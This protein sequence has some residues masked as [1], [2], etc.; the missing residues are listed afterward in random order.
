MIDD[1]TMTDYSYIVSNRFEAINSR[2][3]KLMAEQIKDIGKLSPSNL[4][5]LEQ[6]TKMDANIDEINRLLAAECNKA[7]EE[8][9]QIYQLSGMSLYG[10]SSKYYMAKGVNQIP[11]SEN[12]WMQNHIQSINKLTGGTF[13]NMAN[14]TV[15]RDNYRGLVDLAID[16]VASGQ[17]G[18]N[19]AIISHLRDAARAGMSVQYESGITR[20]LDSAVRMNILEGVRQVNN[21]VRLQ[22]GKEFGADGV[23]VSAH[24]LCAEDHIDI[25]GQQYALG[26][27]DI[28]IDGVTY[29][30]FEQMNGS[31]DREISTLN[32][33]HI[34]FPIVLGISEPT[35][36]DEELDAFKRNSHETVDIGGKKMTKYEA[37][38]VLRKIETAMRYAKD[39]YIAAEALG[40]DAGQKAMDEASN[41][42]YVL[43]KRY[44]DICKRAGLEEHLDR[45]YV[46]GFS[47]RQKAPKPVT[48]KA[49]SANNINQ[50]KKNVGNGSKS[51]IS[52]PQYSHIDA[53]REQYGDF[54]EQYLEFRERVDM[55][56]KM[57]YN[58]VERIN[59]TKT[60]LDI[61]R[62]VGGGDMTDG[63]CASV[64]LAY[65]GQKCG[66]N[67]LDFRGGKSMKWFSLKSTKQDMFKACGATSIEEATMKSSLSNGK[68]IL[69]NMEKGKE[70]YL[71]VG[72]HASIVRLN[73]DGIMQYLELQSSTDN[74]WQNFS[75]NI[76]DTLK[77][78]FGCSSSS[79]KFAT[80]YL[81][82]IDQ[83]KDNKEF[84]NML[85]YINTNVKKQKK[86][87]S[88]HA[89]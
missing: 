26:D 76:I 77:Y 61:I 42:L 1:K 56:W 81:T 27:K 19:A 73:D 72:Q 4:H 30:S 13:R 85:G 65:V 66:Y 35:Y 89:K 23:E 33:K 50:S 24:A 41:K 82:D 84:G 22:M 7:I 40:G 68:K 31:L 34:I 62:D 49:N 9:Q 12:K 10:D 18:Y 37:S 21:G 67:V 59:G 69:S 44:K 28:T 5:R 20:R 3:I 71:S 74:G 6:M 47:G 70:Y 29:E 58:D 36:T 55:G 38:Q 17:E 46:P 51:N 80:A 8:L 88:G 48:I 79:K 45:A 16:S 2:Y 78:R 14:T 57:K 60:E 11:F 83:L 25:Q 32:C 63:S 53:L 87:V 54:T 52:I 86:G 15:A 75:D 39:D 64:A 43:D